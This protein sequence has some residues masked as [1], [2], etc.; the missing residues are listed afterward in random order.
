MYNPSS[1]AQELFRHSLLEIIPPKHL[2]KIVDDGISD[3]SPIT[4]FPDEFLEMSIVFR[5][6]RPKSHFV[7]N[8]PGEG[9]IKTNAPGKYHPTRT[10]IDN[11]AKF[12]LDSLNGVLYTDDRQVVSLKATKVLDSEGDCDGATDVSITVVQDE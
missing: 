5:L 9:R 2:P 6:K 12:V 8:K 3:D 11:L 10:D 7:N 1:G 4:F